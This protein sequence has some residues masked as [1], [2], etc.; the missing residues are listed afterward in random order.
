MGTV[1]TTSQPWSRRRLTSGRGAVTLADA[2][3][4]HD[5]EQG[6]ARA[7]QLVDAVA[8]RS[9]ATAPLAAQPERPALLEADVAQRPGYVPDRVFAVGQRVLLGVVRPGGVV[10]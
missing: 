2:R 5:V 6:V 4:P 3:R 10:L 1:G 8:H 9:L 7:V